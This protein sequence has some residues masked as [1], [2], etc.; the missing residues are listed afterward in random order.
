MMWRAA[1]FLLFM[2][3]IASGCNSRSSSGPWV[4]DI[5]DDDPQMNAAIEK[6]RATLPDFVRALRSPK[7]SQ[8]GFAIKTPITDGTH[9]EHMWLN[10]I[11]FD[12]QKYHGTVDNQPAKVTGVKLGSKRSIDPQQV[13]DW[14]YLDNRKL[15][16]G[17]TIRVVREKLGPKEREEFD[18]NAPFALD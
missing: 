7:A 4:T 16:G 9:T 15:V 1:F 2:V 11:T 3:T 17:Y 6:A 18:K 14:M 13:T 8:T 5:D 10:R 12:G